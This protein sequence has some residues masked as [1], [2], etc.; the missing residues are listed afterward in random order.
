M[1]NRLKKQFLSLMGRMDN[2]MTL[3]EAQEFTSK[4]IL[5]EQKKGY[6]KIVGSFMEVLGKSGKNISNYLDDV[7]IKYNSF[8]D[9]VLKKF[10]DA[11]V[12]YKSTDDLITALKSLPK[13]TDIKNYFNELEKSMISSLE[14][15]AK[16]NGELNILEQAKKVMSGAAFPKDIPI[17]SLKPYLE[18]LKNIENI[19]IHNK[20]LSIIADMGES[21]KSG[22]TDILSIFTNSLLKN[23][24]DLSVKNIMSDIDNLKVFS[25]ESDDFLNDIFE[26]IDDLGTG[27]KNEDDILETLGKSF[28][29]TYKFKEGF[30]RRMLNPKS[31]MSA[32]F[33]SVMKKIS[34]LDLDNTVIIKQTKSN[35]GDVI[36]FVEVKNAT[37]EKI[38]I[39]KNQLNRKFKDVT[40]EYNFK[41]KSGDVKDG[42]IN[43][44]I[45]KLKLTGIIIAVIIVDLLGI[46]YV[47]TKISCSSEE[48]YLG[49]TD[50][51]VD[52]TLENMQ[53]DRIS[54][55]DNCFNMNYLTFSNT[56]IG[57]VL[58]G[59]F[60]IFSD[61]VE[62]LGVEF[63][64]YLDV[65]KVTIKTKI[66]AKLNCC[67]KLNLENTNEAGC[68]K[69]C[70]KG[71]DGGD[72]A[73][74]LDD[75]KQ[76]DA[77]KNITD[78]LD[79]EGSWYDWIPGLESIAEKKKR[80]LEK[81]KNNGE[82]PKEFFNNEGNF[83]ISTLVTEMCEVSKKLSNSCRAQQIINDWNTFNDQE[84]S[85]DTCNSDE[86]KK[87]F[88]QQKEMA[89]YIENGLVVDWKEGSEDELKNVIDIGDLM[90]KIEVPFKSENENTGEVENNA[91]EVVKKNIEYIINRENYCKCLKN[92]DAE[93]CGGV[94]TENQGQ[95]KVTLKT[96]K[97][98]IDEVI[99]KE[100]TDTTCDIYEKYKDDDS[101]DKLKKQIN[102]YG[103]YLT[104][105]GYSEVDVEDGKE[106]IRKVKIPEYCNK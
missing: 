102:Y 45:Q 32:N 40:D 46:N 101:K 76:T 39:I 75:I 90:G 26:R 16:S 83:N 82:L 74:I 66:D 96:V 48:G 8:L 55:E 56:V 65:L 93:G 44:N 63:K 5:N 73:D 91:I 67:Y 104:K 57:S 11:S 31:A 13:A 15:I 1:D 14:N 85:K 21:V 60:S 3:N 92:P 72:C 41:G 25:K 7:Q 51:D 81:W 34:S 35:G 24:S 58:G 33:D 2:R 53:S 95:D 10:D 17:E 89:I 43:A 20:V 77:F 61:T 54:R 86:H 12:L 78:F 88:L 69:S 49:D 28:D 80:L 19:K 70:E 98:Y 105:A 38:N 103:K 100:F 29:N 71:C 52:E 94:K 36:T 37:P 6:Q 22:D 23:N 79:T 42:I 18:S 59:V 4:I 68:T 47:W 106:Y 99:V 84:I 64:S 50:E 62:K 30:F 27:L 97:E 87:L 9:D